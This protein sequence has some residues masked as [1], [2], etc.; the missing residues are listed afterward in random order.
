MQCSSSGKLYEFDKS[1]KPSWKRHTQSK[2]STIETSLLPTKG[3]IYFGQAGAHS[4]SLFLVTK[5]HFLRYRFGVCFVCEFLRVTALVIWSYKT[6]RM[7]RLVIWSR[8][9]CTRES[10]D[11]L[12]MEVQRNTS[13]LPLSQLIKMN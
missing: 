7:C 6:F 5:V 4:M 3:C 2:G 8:G 9:G 1:S 13:W 10:G 11:G 12:V